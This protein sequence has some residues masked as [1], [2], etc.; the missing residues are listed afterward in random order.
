MTTPLETSS[1]VTSEDPLRIG[2]FVLKSRLIVGSGRY[3]D[4][5]VMSESL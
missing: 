2:S 4:V 5:Q 1:Q 3:Q